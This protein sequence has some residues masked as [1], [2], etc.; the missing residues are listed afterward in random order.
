VQTAFIVDCRNGAEWDINQQRSMAYM[1][2]MGSRLLI[3]RLLIVAVLIGFAPRPVRADS[4]AQRGPSARGPLC[5]LVLGQI[6]CHDS[7]RTTG[8]PITPS[9]RSVVDFA[10]APDGEWL[11]YRASNTV[12]IASIYGSGRSQQ[13][14]SSAAPPATLDRSASTI[15]WSPNGLAIAYVT[16]GGFRV[17]FPTPTGEPT[18]VDV[19]D[20]LAVNL[21][22]STDG[23]RL[24]AQA[25]DKSW[26]LFAVQ[27]TDDGGRVRDGVRGSVQRTRAIDQAAD[28]AWLNGDELVVAAV[29][30]GLSR[31]SAV[32]GGTPAWI[33]P[34]EHFTKLT[35]TSGGEVLA[36]H[37]DPGDT[38]GSVVSISADGQVTPLG[39]SKIDATAEWGPD[40]ETL[41]YITS[42]T[43][44]L[45]DR[46]TGA[47]NTLPLKRVGRLVWLPPAP[48]L[49]S[50][51]PLDADLYFLA[52]D[53]N[54]VRQVWRLPRSGLEP[55]IQVSHETYDVR[56][57]A[58][59]RTQVIVKTDQQT[60][61]VPLVGATPA[62]PETAILPT[63]TPS[64]LVVSGDAAGW[65]VTLSATPLATSAWPILDLQDQSLVKPGSSLL[66]LRRIG[67]APG[68]DTIQLCQVTADAGQM[69][70]RSRIF[71][72]SNARLSP[73]GRFVA[74]WQRVGTI[75]QLVILDLDSGRKLR[76]QGTRDISSLR[77]VL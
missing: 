72:F 65:T 46:A 5:A 76:I 73:T 45:I 62:V 52:P 51:V 12:T 31:V 58:A 22:F 38:I 25:D 27:L 70:S 40:G 23:G 74:G 55:V 16:A 11:V 1:I 60:I 48:P 44:I 57:F 49:S 18:F 43:P 21:R 19:N 42:G 4:P 7:P 59:S 67:W 3:R 50:S 15:A 29:S 37:P 56:D 54:G 9:G 75:S 53:S 35:T 17:A 6:V 77:W 36:L 34:T 39:S 71:A 33:V 30:G 47:E 13:I 10:V 26:S 8:R 14:D 2:R 28:V 64:P 69:E 41:Y 63:S 61:R 68:P 66:L 24:A 32:N 20:R